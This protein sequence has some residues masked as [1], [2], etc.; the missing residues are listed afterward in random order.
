MVRVSMGHSGR[1][2]FAPALKARKVTNTSAKEL[3]RH[4]L[5]IIEG[6]IIT[7]KSHR[8]PKYLPEGL[9]HFRRYLESILSTP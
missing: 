5:A 4:M 7:A 8:Q 9:K 2:L 3:A 1:K 6:A